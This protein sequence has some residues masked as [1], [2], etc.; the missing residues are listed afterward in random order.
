MS[1]PQ[2]E[3]PPEG[4][5]GTGHGPYR[6]VVLPVSGMGDTAAAHRVAN[7]MRRM[8]G[9]IAVEASP[10]LDA[11]TLTL[12]P[13][14]ATLPEVVREL[15][16]LEVAVIDALVPLSIRGMTSSA[17]VARVRR[18]LEGVD[19]VIEAQINPVLNRAD[20]RLISTARDVEALMQAVRHAGYGVTPLGEHGAVA[21]V[22]TAAV[23]GFGAG[24]SRV[25]SLILGIVG[26][27]TVPL[28]ANLAWRV[29]GSAPLFGVTWAF[30]LSSVVLSLGGARY[31]L[32]AWRA[33]E[34][35][36]ATMDLLVVLGS[37]SAY[38][39]SV[40]AWIAVPS[41]GRNLYFETAAAIIAFVRLGKWLEAV[42]K[43]GTTRAIR[44]LMELRAKSARVIRDG[45]LVS[46][47]IEA[48][49][50][51]DVV[52][53]KPY[54]RIP[55]DG[56][57]VRG[58]STVDASMITG[59]GLPEDKTV[60]DLVTGGTM[61]GGGT[62]HVEASRAAADST[63]ARIIA[64]VEEAQARRVPLQ[65]FIDR[66]T[67]MFVP[68]V[69]G[70]AAFTLFA[71]LALEGNFSDA[72]NAAVSVLVIACPC[73]LGLAAPTALVAGTGAAA[74]AGILIR[75]I[76]SLE[77]AYRV[78][79]VLFDKT[80][81]LT[82]GRPFVTSVEALDGDVS[83]LLYL[84]ASAQ[85]GNEHPLGRA[86][87][88]YAE[89]YGIVPAA[90]KSFEAMPGRGVR[91]T[92]EGQTTILI[93]NLPLMESDGV[94]MTVGDWIAPML[95]MK[96]RSAIWVAENGRLIGGLSVCDPMRV[97]AR[98]AVSALQKDRIACAIVSG[99]ADSAVSSVAEALSIKNAFCD[100]LPETKI[101]IVR[102]LQKIGRSV[103]MVGDGINDAPALAQADLGIAVGSAA[104]AALQSAD[105]TLL[106]TDVI[107]VTNALAVAR[108]T[109]KK[110]RQNLALAFV[111]N[112][113]ALPL[114]A[115]GLL[116]PTVAGAAMA[117]SSI[118]VVFNAF[119][120]TRWTP[121]LPD[122]APPDSPADP[123]RA[124]TQGGDKPD[125]PC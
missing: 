101:R 54:E 106:R 100:A 43:H 112:L 63:L 121:R 12:D 82:E 6:R 66:T 4:T 92:I 7:R 72:I 48:V 78:D 88:E 49:A 55:V 94:D 18:A 19:G 95:A 120:L 50:V 60:G 58:E 25:E 79:T 35:R 38:F 28:L 119:L 21:D 116:S 23:Y 98:R 96:G 53:V 17:C 40:I 114:A 77:K 67:T 47:P 2:T 5:P 27:L 13:A 84:A 44:S 22:E 122:A 90:L 39:Y 81:T 36:A 97:D 8:D 91:A 56:V 57:V 125:T 93:G 46:K 10:A 108:E 37:A 14:R 9:V 124:A 20:V 29:L 118:S 87:L 109:W 69:L 45:A 89:N 51:G 1:A 16:G 41:A 75:D 76:D 31:V 33:I 80:G 34:S 3:T 70:V 86:I 32:G 111:Y 74:K 102:R 59:A 62:L 99:D 113:I 107:S 64:L 123:C 73:A 103:A 104:D 115:L 24:A 117:A 61:N 11:V 42:V 83:R 65:R 15:E 105:I 85:Q 30:L 68:V 52:M 26:V 110:I 71:W